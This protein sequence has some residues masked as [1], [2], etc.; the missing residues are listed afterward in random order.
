MKSKTLASAVRALSLL[1]LVSATCALASADNWQVQV[2]AQA[3]NKAHQALAFLPNE[4]SI[5]TPATAS[6]GLFQPA[7]YTP[8]LF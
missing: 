7:S 2:G 8:S 3:G 4:L 6:L 5:I 1:L